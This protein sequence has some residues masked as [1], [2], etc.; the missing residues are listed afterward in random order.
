LDGLSPET[1]SP[2]ALT[3]AMAAGSRKPR[4]ASVGVISQPSSSRALMLPA[5]PTV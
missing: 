1:H 3:L 2:A 4:Q 5:E